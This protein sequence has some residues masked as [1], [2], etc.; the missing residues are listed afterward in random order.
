MSKQNWKQVVSA[1][2]RILLAC[3]LVFVQGASAQ[4]ST[5]QIRRK[6]VETQA[7]EKA[8][9]PVTNPNTRTAEPQTE[10]AQG[11]RTEKQSVN[12]S[13]EGIKVHGHWTI[14]VRNPDGTLVTHREFEN[15]YSPTSSFLSNVL[16]RNNSVGLWEISLSGSPQPCFIISSGP[17][18]TACTIE[19]TIINA[20]YAP[21]Y[22]PGLTLSANAGTL[23]LSGNATVQ[24]TGSI[25]QVSTVVNP[26]PNSTPPS[27]PCTGG[28]SIA[29][30]TFTMATLTAGSSTPPVPVSAGQTVQVTVV[31]SFS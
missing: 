4:D 28:S 2:A 12:G 17:Q 30:A 31:I 14:E 27:S 22:F 20:S 29:L 16:A 24:V 1:A 23:V 7:S 10:T 15:A 8:P 25:N 11:I 19:E 13:H 5:M 18:P 3:A 6:Q 26:C 21:P 9:A